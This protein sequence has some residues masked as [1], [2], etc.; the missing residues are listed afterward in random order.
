MLTLINR[1][2]NPIVKINL[3]EG[4]DALQNLNIYTIQSQI[5]LP[6]NI[7]NQTLILDYLLPSPLRLIDS[8]FKLN[9]AF[10]VKKTITGDST[11]YIHLE[12][13]PPFPKDLFQEFRIMP[14]C[15][16]LRNSTNINASNSTFITS[17]PTNQFKSAQLVG[18]LC[19]DMFLSCP[20]MEKECGPCPIARHDLELICD[21][22]STRID[23]IYAYLDG[24]VSVSRVNYG[25]SDPDNDRLEDPGTLDLNLVKRK[26]F[27]TGDTIAMDYR[28]IVIADDDRFKYDSVLFMVSGLT[29][30]TPPT[31]VFTKIEI[32]D[33]STSKKYFCNYPIWDK[34]GESNPIPN[35]VYF[36]LLKTTL[37]NGLIVP[38]NP[39]LL[40]YY[41]AKLPVGFKF[42]KGDSINATIYAKLTNHTGQ[43]I[44]GLGLKFRAFLMDR[45]HLLPDPFSC[46]AINDSITMAT[47]GIRISPLRDTSFICRSAF[48]L[49]T[50]TIQGT[51]ELRNFF[52]FEFRSIYS[53]DSVKIYIQNPYLVLDSI[54]I[55]YVYESVLGNR[56]IA[57]VNY[58]V[59]KNFP[60]WSIDPELLKLHRYDESYTIHV[61][62]YAH[63]T[64]CPQFKNSKNTVTSQFYINENNNSLFYNVVSENTIIDSIFDSR[65]N[66][67]QLYNGNNRFK[68]PN[69]TIHNSSGKINWTFLVSDLDVPGGFEFNIQSKNKSISNVTISSDSILKI[70]KLDSNLIEVTNFSIKQN[71]QLSFSALHS[72]CE[73]DTLLVI[74]R[75][76]CPGDSVTLRDECNLDTFILIIKQRDP[77]LQLKVTQLSIESI[78]CDTLPEITLE[79]FNADKGD[80][81]DV[82]MDVFIPHGTDTI[83]F[84]T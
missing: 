31:N 24:K 49:Y 47:Q 36:V 1:I 14:D 69:N 60:S 74:S 32:T 84:S 21:T 28:T 37:G 19:L 22:L 57:S 18:K 71:Y 64:D 6:K 15:N 25:K 17:C 9:N 81:F 78:L 80:A 63:L 8:S 30:D 26:N 42:E 40:N 39:E 2:K 34:Y 3:K 76:I 4:D 48:E 55:D 7:T 79:I 54:I 53:L 5:S 65:V 45:E 77:E 70:T 38:M 75:W 27:I 50:Y 58:P 66:T 23:S 56:L 16:Y 10:P 62:P 82:Y 61:T 13:L 29:I 41:G 33:Q 52:P 11:I 51:K 44:V 59:R 12:Y 73:E 83:P 72:Y 68:F 35:C 46:M 67:V 20:G 43:K